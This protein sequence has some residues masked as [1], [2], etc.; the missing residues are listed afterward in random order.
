MLC[1]LDLIKLFGISTQCLHQKYFH[2]SSLEAGLP[3]YI[4]TCY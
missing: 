4:A 1:I 3:V 2:M